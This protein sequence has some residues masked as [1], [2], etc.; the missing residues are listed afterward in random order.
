MKKVNYL[1]VAVLLAAVAGTTM[2][3]CKKEEALKGI[4]TYSVAR[5]NDLFSQVDGTIEFLN[6]FD[7]SVTYKDATG[8]LI[9]ESNVAL[10]WSFR[11]EVEAPFTATIDVKITR[12][13]LED[14][15]YEFP[16]PNGS[17]TNITIESS[18]KRLSEGYPA[19]GTGSGLY[20]VVDTWLAANGR[21]SFSLVFTE[22][23][24]NQHGSN[25]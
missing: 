8:K 14:P 9:T 6:V 4:V 11:Q 17:L 15:P 10:P 7:V 3:S 24:L 1:L 2:I 5:P 23:T 13:L 12:K 25:L 22:E 21:V 19:P 16:R 18:G 20:S